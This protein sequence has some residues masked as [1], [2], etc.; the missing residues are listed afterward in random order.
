MTTTTTTTATAPPS[1]LLGTHISYISKKSSVL[2]A[3]AHVYGATAYQIFIGSPQAG[4]RAP[5][6]QLTVDDYLTR[7]S[8]T[9]FTAKNTLVHA[10]Y[11]INLARRGAEAVGHMSRF[12]YSLDAASRCKCGGL[13]LHPGSTLKTYSVED[14]IAQIAEC[15]CEALSARANDVDCADILFENMCAKSVIGKNLTELQA[16]IARTRT[17]RDKVGI[18]IDTAHL[19]SSGIDIRTPAQFDAYLR[20]FDR[21]IGPNYLR[22][23]HLNDSVHDCGSYI[24]EHAPI[25]RGKIGSQLFDWIMQQPRFKMI[26][27]VTETH[28]DM[29]GNIEEQRMMRAAS[30]MIFRDKE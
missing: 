24:D 29:N 19:F 8:Y 27:M 17:T 13:V 7:R 10:P 11:S 28:L 23:M 15:V 14:S 4:L 26:P 3:T 20:E 2:F 9:A 1:I 5:I 21:L 16:L 30:G 12:K 18:C 6:D 22:A 25:G